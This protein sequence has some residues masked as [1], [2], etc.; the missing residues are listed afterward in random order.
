[1]GL[2]LS[3]N[4]SGLL[5]LAI[6][7]SATSISLEA[8]H[9]SRFPAL[10]SGDW[11]PITVVRASDPSKFEIMRC[12]GR[13][14]D[15]LTVVRGQE[16]TDAI[17]FSAGDVVELRLTSGTL[18]EN[19]PQVEGRNAK[20]L[21]FSIDSVG[22]KPELKFKSGNGEE[23]V[24]RRSDLTTSPTDTTP[25]RVLT[26]GSLG[27]GNPILLTSSDDLD[28]IKSPGIY[29]HSQGNAPANTP[30]PEAGI[31][32]VFKGEPGNF[33]VQAW[34]DRGGRRSFQR[35][36]N[37]NTVEWSNWV[38]F[39]HTGNIAQLISDEIG[40]LKGKR[41]LFLEATAPP[42][43]TQDTSINDRVLRI[44]NSAGG[45]LGGSW[46]IS[47]LSASVSVG[48]TTLSVS[49]IPSHSHTV[50]FNEVSVTATAIDQFPLT[51]G[52]KVHFSTGATGGSG[53][54]THS[55]SASISSN[56]T[57]RPAY[58]DVIACR[59]D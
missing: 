40:E 33:V 56:G 16:G 46:T 9:G 47:G 15:T 53:S 35:A 34:L 22:G 6:S 41:M 45:G 59:K 8:G 58:V 12:T 14:G 52:N 11:F 25:G 39:Y 29:R 2:K 51:R 1:M 55:A 26:V 30:I 50:S 54:H 3:N 19:F 17:T 57:W 28:D 32:T 4:A 27:L 20:N 38:E 10:G 13:S 18:E 31:V 7:D 23:T 24:V 48:A 37:P 21:R 5:A 42:G 43:W 44:V 36:F 49:Q